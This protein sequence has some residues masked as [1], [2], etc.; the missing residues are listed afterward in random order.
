[1]VPRDSPFFG[2]RRYESQG[3]S[4][5]MTGE[6]P[7]ALGLSGGVTSK[8]GEPI[9]NFGLILMQREKSIGEE[10]ARRG[11]EMAD[12]IDDR[13]GRVAPTREPGHRQVGE[14]NRFESEGMEGEE[15]YP[16]LSDV[17]SM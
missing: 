8:P 1:M 9:E 2:V 13:M 6:G 11:Q 3:W 5:C 7:D 16:E 4:V 14:G 10:Y 15:I 17:R 12:Q